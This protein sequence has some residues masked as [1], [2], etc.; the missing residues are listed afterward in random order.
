MDV[1]AN[2]IANV[3]RGRRIK[4]ECRHIS[5]TIVQ[6]YDLFILDTVVLYALCLYSGS[7]FR[8]RGW[9]FRFGINYC[10]SYPEYQSLYI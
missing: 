8:L 5:R 6:T 1:N 4:L 2:L 3:K 10:Y 9:M 7:F